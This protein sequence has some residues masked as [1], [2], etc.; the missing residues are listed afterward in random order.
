MNQVFAMNVGPKKNKFQFEA[1]A[2]N[3]FY[4][5]P[6]LK[7]SLNKSSK[8][9][10]EIKITLTDRGFQIG[11]GT[12]KLLP[13]YDEIRANN[14]QWMVWAD[15]RYQ[16][17]PPDGVYCSFS[18]IPINKED[19]NQGYKL[20]IPRNE[21][22]PYLIANRSNPWPFHTKLICTSVKRHGIEDETKST[23]YFDD[24]KDVK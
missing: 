6:F 8:F 20:M 15:A 10:N 3:K 19:H 5:W 18:F 9:S 14:Y 24:P 22:N 23:W 7:T 2:V 4:V 17:S 16:Y 21:N 13:E 12:K 1:D 11:H